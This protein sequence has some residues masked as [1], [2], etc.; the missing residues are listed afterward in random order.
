M[1]KKKDPSGGTPAKKKG[2]PAQKRGVR[3][4]SAKTKPRVDLWEEDEEPITPMLVSEDPLFM[5]SVEGRDVRVLAE[6][7]AP[8]VRF[9][10]LGVENTLIFFGSARTLGPKALKRE[11]TKAE[12]AKDRGRIAKLHRLAEVGKYYDDARE[13]G[14]LL[15][16]W[17][18]T[19]PERYAVCT[20]GGPGIMEAGNRGAH[21]AGMPN[22]GLNIELPFEQQPNPFITPELNFHFNYFFIRKY[23]LL[24]MAKAL[25]IFPGGLGTLD[26]LFEVLTLIQTKKMMKPIPVVLYGTDFW[27]KVFNLKHLADT[28]MIDPDD[29]MLYR[30]CDT[31]EDAFKYITEGI[32]ANRNYYNELK[33]KRSGSNIFE[34]L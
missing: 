14:R 3:T 32:A 31:I 24:Y 27:S 5:R 18:K 9:R 10:K 12:K 19:Q 8:G 6:F 21:D 11:L 15:S 23:W 17:S 13:L 34:R 26:E 25:V 7:M 20:G 33:K 28:G 29:L 4:R 2:S 16:E 1:V 22:I 30:S